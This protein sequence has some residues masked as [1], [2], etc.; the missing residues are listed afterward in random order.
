MTGRRLLVALTAILLATA[1]LPPA[2]AWSVTVR[3]VHR[4]EA[5]TATLAE[6]LRAPDAQAKLER[7]AQ[8]AAVLCGDGRVPSVVPYGYVGGWLTESRGPLSSAVGTPVAPDPWGNCYIVNVRNPTPGAG[9]WVISAG[10]NGIV[11]SMWSPAGAVMLGGDD[12][13]ARLK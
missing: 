2:A 6:Q 4:A 7:L 1:V 12:I 13:G 11:D 8:S 10:P 9:V 3:R 5:M